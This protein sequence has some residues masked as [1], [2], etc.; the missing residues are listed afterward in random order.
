LFGLEKL[1]APERA[2]AALEGA[3]DRILMAQNSNQRAAA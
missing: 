3:L 2:V 1:H